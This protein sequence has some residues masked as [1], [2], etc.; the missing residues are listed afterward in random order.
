VEIFDKNKNLIAIVHKDKDFKDGK[1]FYTD[2][3]KDFQFGT[4]NLDKGEIIENHI[5]NSQKREIYSTSEAI[6]VLSGMLKIDL[7]DN[8]KNFIDSVIIKK[9]DSILIFDGGHGIQ[10]QEKSKFIEFKQG[11]YIQD[12]DKK[13]F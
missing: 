9:N 7:F 11:P 8:E 2:N 5:H 12:L 6:V 4:F 3:E 10:V 1:A 13:H